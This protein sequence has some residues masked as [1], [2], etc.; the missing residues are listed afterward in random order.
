[1]QLEL[2]A[3]LYTCCLGETTKVNYIDSKPLEVCHV[4]RE[5]NHRV[6]KHIA[7]KGKTSKG[8]FYGLKL[9]LICNQRGE[10][11]RLRLTSGNVSDNNAAFLKTFLNDFQGK[12][13][14][15]KGYLTKLK[16]HF[17]KNG[18]KIISKVRKNMK[19]P[20]LTGEERYYLKKRGLIE[21]VFDQMVN[22]CQIEH[23]R[24]RSPRNFAV[25]LWAG[26]I[27][28]AFLGKLPQIQ[29]FQPK[30]LEQSVVLLAD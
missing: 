13:Y 14:G 24:H 27:A 17:E 19:K 1:M 21:T 25:N 10:P 9:H 12:I 16:G 8:Y 26:I 22:I 29:E 4:K 15:D 30:I 2:Y 5:K 11:V 3:F 7:Q 6:F 18:C 28:Y 23:T 20:N